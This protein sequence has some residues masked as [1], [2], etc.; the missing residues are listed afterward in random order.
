MGF[1]FRKSKSFGPVRVNFSKSGISWSVGTKGV[2]YTKKAGGGTRSTYSIPGTGLS[3]VSES[4]G[5]KKS[6]SSRSSQSVDYSDISIP[7]YEDVPGS[8]NTSDS[9]TTNCGKR[10]GCLWWFFIGWWWW[11]VELFVWLFATPLF[12]GYKYIKYLLKREATEKFDVKKAIDSDTLDWIN[13]MTAYS[14]QF[15]KTNWFFIVCCFFIP[16]IAI[17]IVLLKRDAWSLKKKAIV[18]GVVAFWWLIIGIGNC[19]DTTTPPTVSG[20]D[21]V[22]SDSSVSGSDR[23]FTLSDSDNFAVSSSDA[24]G[25]QTPTTTSATTTTTTTATTTTETTTTTEYVET[26]WIPQS[27][28]KYHWKSSCSNM[29]NPREVTKEEA[30]R[31]GYEPCGRCY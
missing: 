14:T 19:G 1:R 22:T 17:A 31:R 4:S 15:Y 24:V 10:H 21:I 18:C 8:S 3:Y 26:V 11:I 2:R 9:I 7:S 29:E 27:G 28:S 23:Y 12:I 25:R 16:I 30:I 20:S 13:S 6:S 5:K